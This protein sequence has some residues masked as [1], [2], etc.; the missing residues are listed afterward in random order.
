MHKAKKEVWTMM[1]EWKS[2]KV[3]RVHFRCHGN[4]S[5]MHLAC[6]TGMAKVLEASFD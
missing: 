6:P 3:K 5:R 4:K 2:T 1:D